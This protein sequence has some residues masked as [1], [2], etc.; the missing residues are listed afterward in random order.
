[1]SDSPYKKNNA[2]RRDARASKDTSEVPRANRGKKDRK[3]WCGGHEGREHT[4]E[5]K[6]R[7]NN[8]LGG[9]VRFCSVCESCNES[10]WMI[11]IH[12]RIR[13]CQHCNKRMRQ[14]T[15]EETLEAVAAVKIVT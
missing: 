11:E 1:M 10:E 6:E 2:D 8:L 3:R 5:V 9:Y 7:G 4:P 14:A 13:V 12:G 15:Q